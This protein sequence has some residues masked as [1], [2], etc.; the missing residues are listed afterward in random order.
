MS[1]TA[2]DGTVPEDLKSNLQTSSF[3]RGAEDNNYNSSS[4]VDSISFD[5]SSDSSN[6]NSNEL[7]FKGTV[8]AVTADTITINGQTFTVVTQDDLTTLFTPGSVFEIEFRQNQDGTISIFEFHPEDG[9]SDYD[10]EFKGMVE[11]V[12]PDTITIGGETFLVATLEDL[13]TL[14]T[15]DQFYEIKYI[16]NEDGSITIV[17][18]HSE[19]GDDD[20]SD[21]SET[22]FKGM[23]EA[24]TP[25]TITIDGETFLV[26]TLE[27]LTTLFTTGQ[28]YEIEYTS[29]EDGTITI[30]DFHPEDEDDD[31]SDDDWD[32]IDDSDDDDDDDDDDNSDDNN[33]DDD[34]DDNDD[35]SR[36]N[37]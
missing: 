6:S 32:E 14:F 25:D 21:D 28:L 30:V 36:N 4:S 31:L 11:A 12:T 27:D 29:N 9:S 1:L 15:N 18:S 7:K 13:T 20:M 16:F 17:S 19:D 23:V 24:V 10:V 3:S 35:N 5:S 34:D 33:D 8:E 37:N 22:E 26:A 2:C